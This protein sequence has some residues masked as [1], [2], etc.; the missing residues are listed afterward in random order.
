MT[1]AAQ[2]LDQPFATMPD[3][4]RAH[5][6][7][8][9]GHRAILDGDRTVTFAELDALIDRAAAALQRDGVG[10]GGAAAMC[11]LSSI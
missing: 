2:L 7:E 11:A 3:M 1:T 10:N 4:I 8:R 9:P 5:A 6:K